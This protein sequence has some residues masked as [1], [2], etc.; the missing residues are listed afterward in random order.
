MVSAIVP[1]YNETSEIANCIKSLLKQNI[2]EDYEII[3]VD[4]GSDDGTK[5]IIQE[6]S[7]KMIEENSVQT[8]YAA[9]NAGIRAGNGE[10]FAFTDADCEVDSNWLSAG[11]KSIREDKTV[12]ALAGK[13]EGGRARTPVERRLNEIGWLSQEATMNHEFLPY[14]QTANAFYRREVFEKVGLFPTNW[15][16]AGDADLAWRMQINTKYKLKYEGGA[17]VVHNHRSDI[18]SL[19]KQ[20]KKWGHGK[21]LLK[22]KYKYGSEGLAEQMTRYAKL[23]KEVSSKSAI[24]LLRVLQEKTTKKKFDLRYVLLCDMAY[25]VGLELGYVMGYLGIKKY[26]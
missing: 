8:P 24:Y 14:P 15:V 9:R 19:F 17:R 5:K 21:Y 13:I 3:V 26:K 23:V 2:R 12:G 16:S 4:N 6:Y 22:N 18:I 7:V 10:I 20:C 1:V 25:K 11:V